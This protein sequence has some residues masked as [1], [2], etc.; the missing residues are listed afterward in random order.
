VLECTAN[1]NK[2]YYLQA[3]TWRDKTQ[4]CFLSS[5][6]VGASYGSTVHRRERGKNTSTEIEAPR[7]QQD[8]V[9]YFNAVDRNNCDSADYST[10]IR[11]N[12][13]YL[14]IFGWILDRVLHVMYVVVSYLAHSGIQNDEWGVYLKKKS[15]QHD[16]QID[17]GIALLNRG[18][19]WDW[20][21]KSKKP[22]WMRQTPLVPCNCKQC[23]FCVK[24]MTNGI[25]HPSEK[26]QKVTVDYKCRTRVKTN[27]CTSERVDLGL[28]AGRYCRMCYR[29]Q[30]STE[31]KA[32]ERKG[33]CR[34]SR[35]GCAICK[36]PICMECWKEGYDRHA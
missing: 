14:R 26:K 3:T 33:R 11:T 8:Y 15:G 23:Y 18:I 10:S 19:E 25:Y 28:K 35:L 31:L 32:E 30:V 36:E 20:D 4:V 1:Q 34:T 16:F 22:G 29:K 13:Y 21:G 17:L 27:K 12:R 9:K 2:T 7:A 5:N 24:E 6:K